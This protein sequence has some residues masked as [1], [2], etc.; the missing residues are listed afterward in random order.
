M[1]AANATLSAALV[2]M[3][4]KPAPEQAVA[5]TDADKHAFLPGSPTASAFRS[6]RRRGTVAPGTTW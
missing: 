4:D 1:G 5:L 3:G 6:R 2:V